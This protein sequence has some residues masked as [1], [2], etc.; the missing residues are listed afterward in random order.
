MTILWCSWC[1]HWQFCP[2]TKFKMCKLRW[3]HFLIQSFAIF[4]TRCGP[5]VHSSVVPSRTGRALSQLLVLPRSSV[6]PSWPSLPPPLGAWPSWATRAP[7]HSP[8]R[9]LGCLLHQ[10]EGSPTCWKGQMWVSPLKIYTPRALCFPSPPQISAKKGSPVVWVPL[11]ILAVN[12]QKLKSLKEGNKQQKLE[13]PGDVMN[14][15]GGQDRK[16]CNSVCI[17]CFRRYLWSDISLISVRWQDYRKRT[18]QIRIARG[19]DVPSLEVQSWP[20]IN[21]HL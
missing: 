2:R 17:H 6:R 16:G 11:C 15:A 14:G 21:H 5:Q 13:C 20:F 8:S 10:A 7:P 18:S 1:H 9:R 19:C 3:D 4:G 12:R